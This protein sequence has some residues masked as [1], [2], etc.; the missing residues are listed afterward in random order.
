MAVDFFL[1]HK[2]DFVALDLANDEIKYPA[3]PFI[4]L[5]AR[6]RQ[7]GLAITI[8]AGETNLPQAPANVRQA[9]EMLGAKRIGH[10]VMS[11]KDESVLALLRERQV[12][13]EVCP[14]SN[15]MIGLFPTLE[16]HPIA[17]LRRVGVLVTVSTDDPGIFGHSLNEEYVDLVVAG[18]ASLADL[19][20]AN[21]TAA[22]ASFLSDEIKARHWLHA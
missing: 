1:K 8:H 11:I 6:A 20:Q 10:G 5:F 19:R 14:R 16:K 4:P 9:V 13:L 7:E 18:M 17:A 15:I 22:R 21:E 12:I 2:E 3:D